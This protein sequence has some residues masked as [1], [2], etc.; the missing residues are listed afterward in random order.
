MCPV[1]KFLFSQFKVRTDMHVL[2]SLL[3]LFPLLTLAACY[4]GD[5]GY[6]RPVGWNAGWYN[7]YYGGHRGWYDE[8]GYWRGWRQRGNW[9]D[10]RVR[11]WR[12][13]RWGRRR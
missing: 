5:Y 4:G 9:H 12:D 2:R 1:A 7:G 13:P 11:G 10:E 8:R 3:V 6:Y